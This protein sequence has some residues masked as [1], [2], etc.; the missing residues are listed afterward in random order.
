LDQIPHGPDL[1]GSHQ[2]A[3]AFNVGRKN[4]D[5]PA[6]GIN[7]FRQ[8]MPLDPAGSLSWDWLVEHSKK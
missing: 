3:I 6:L 7:R 1:V 4:R 2:A 8:N 5:Q